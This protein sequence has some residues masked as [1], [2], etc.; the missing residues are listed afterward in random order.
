MRSKKNKST[1]KYQTIKE[2]I[3][4]LVQETDDKEVLSFVYGFMIACM[5][6]EQSSSV[7]KKHI[8]QTPVCQEGT[9]GSVT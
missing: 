4:E 9:F 7:K 5:R 6:K 1:G 3:G 8:L 2:L